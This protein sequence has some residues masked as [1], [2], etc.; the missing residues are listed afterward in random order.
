MQ[1]VMCNVQRAMAAPRFWASF[2][3]LNNPTPRGAI[4]KFQKGYG[5]VAR[6]W[7]YRPPLKEMQIMLCV[8]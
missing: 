7:G 4:S 3:H 1:Y 6:D 5:G 2:M 8:K